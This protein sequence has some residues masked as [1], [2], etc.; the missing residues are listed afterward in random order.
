[1]P[2]CGQKRTEWPAQVAPQTNALRHPRAESGAKAT[3]RYVGSTSMAVIGRVSGT[4]YSFMMP[5]ARVEVDAR[6][7]PSLAAVPHL[8]RVA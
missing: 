7:A 2:C 1:M 6:D 5:G 4:R 8:R 3:F